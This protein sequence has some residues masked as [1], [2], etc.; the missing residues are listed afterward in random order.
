MPRNRLILA[1]LLAAK[2]AESIG[3]S[4]ANWQV[5]RSTCKND[6]GVTVEWCLSCVIG[7]YGHR[8]CYHPAAGYLIPCPRGRHR[9][10]SRRRAARTTKL[11]D[12]AMKV[13]PL[14]DRIVV[15]R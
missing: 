1:S 13:R 9:D 15:R 2:P 10:Y 14:G 4:V 8:T 7:H 3:T 11:G 6:H 12:T 5:A